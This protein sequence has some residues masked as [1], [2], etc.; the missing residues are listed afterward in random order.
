MVNAICLA[1]GGGLNSIG[2][3]DKFSDFIK[4]GEAEAIIEVELFAGATGLEKDGNRCIRRH[5]YLDNKSDFYDLTPHPSGSGWREASLNAKAVKELTASHDVHVDNLCVFLA[6]DCV[7]RFAEMKPP[8]LLLETEKAANGKFHEQHQRLIEMRKEEKEYEKTVVGVTRTL[9]GKRGELE[10]LEPE[11]KRREERKEEE[12]KMAVMKKRRPWIEF[13]EEEQEGEVLKEKVDAMTKAVEE[14]KRRVRPLRRVLERA[15]KECKEAEAK[16]KETQTAANTLSQRRKELVQTLQTLTTNVESRRGDIRKLQD[17]EEQFQ[18]EL[19]RRTQRVEQQ[20]EVVR[21]LP[22]VKEAQEKLRGLIDESRVLVRE[23][24]VVKG[25]ISQIQRDLGEVK[26]EMGEI[27]SRRAQRRQR[28]TRRA[29]TFFNKINAPKFRG[30]YELVQQ[31]R[32]RQ[33]LHRVKLNTDPHYIHDPEMRRRMDDSKSE[34]YVLRGEVFG[35]LVL[36]ID[37]KEEQVGVILENMINFPRKLMYVCCE[38]SDFYY[39]SN[40]VSMISIRP[41]TLARKLQP[42]MLRARVDLSKLGIG[43][44]GGYLYEALSA[45]PLVMSFL[46]DEF[47]ISTTPYFRRELT[48]DEFDRVFPLTAPT[49]NTPWLRALFTPGHQHSIRFSKYGSKDRSMTDTVLEPVRL[50]SRAVEDEG[51][52]EEEKLAALRTAMQRKDAELLEVKKKEEVI[53][54]Q[55][56][57]NGKERE[58]WENITRKDRAERERLTQYRK[59]L[60]KLQKEAGGEAKKERLRREITKIQEQQVKRITELVEVEEQWVDTGM[61]VDVATIVAQHKA[62]EKDFIDTKASAAGHS[63]RKVAEEKKKAEDA[64]HKHRQGLQALRTAALRECREEEVMGLGW[65]SDTLSLDELDE[66]IS[67]SQTTLDSFHS[68]DDAQLEQR[69][70]QLRKEVEGLTHDLQMKEAQHANYTQQITRAKDEWLT[71]IRALVGHVNAA[72]AAYFRRL[73]N[74]GEVALVESADFDHF[75]IQ[76]RVAFNVRKGETPHLNTLS[77]SFHSGGEKSVTTMLYLLSLQEVTNAPFRIVDEI[78]QGMDPSNEEAIFNQ[79]VYASSHYSDHSHS[80][81]RAGERAGRGEDPDDEDEK[82]EAEV[83]LAR[84]MKEEAKL[85]SPQ[86]ILVSPKLLPNL[87]MPEEVGLRVIVAMGGA[88]GKESAE[89]KRKNGTA[90]AWEQPMV[91][92]ECAEQWMSQEEGDEGKERGQWVERE[93]EETDALLTSESDSGSEGGSEVAEADEEESKSKGKRGE[94]RGGRA[95]AA[96]GTDGNDS[97]MELLIEL[98]RQWDGDDL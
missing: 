18:V 6:Q 70:E 80:I 52:G 55:H 28:T 77:G 41:N 61:L 17:D 56:L 64:L 89:K 50:F 62:T 39:L 4:Q 94:R 53:A 71:S 34:D 30:E 16:K 76:V 8:Q 7:G 19:Q 59:E 31:A 1:L 88:I 57:T 85:T 47:P 86:Y 22:D 67:M 87:S 21:D 20:E 10:E 84:R 92:V 42:E 44:V 68:G 93:E 72:F 43:D 24:A 25:E 40:R 73:G 5:L 23:S 60:D 96:A 79:I 98:S 35:P 37:F 38:E 36:E 48:S 51:E 63:L 49:S 82:E 33:R 66:L 3:M 26:L 29:D 83:G 12:E 91:V 27:E 45:P 15:T 95:G 11:M 90:A 78:N 9:E 13:R 74:V 97:E 14:E 69:Y 58:R 75:A 46:A 54:R 65:L 32:E 2:R 81:Q